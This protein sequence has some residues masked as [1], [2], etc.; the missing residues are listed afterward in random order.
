MVA[1]VFMA[2]WTL[3]ALLKGTDYIVADF[4]ARPHLVAWALLAG[5]LWA[6]ANAL[7]VFAIRDVGLAIAFPLWNLN[8][9]VGM[10]WG[11][12]LFGELRG[13]RRAAARVIGGVVFLMTGAC[14][15]AWATTAGGSGSPVET[16]PWQGVAAALGAGV[17]WG[18]MYIP[19]RKAYISGMNP[20]SFVAIFTVGELVTALALAVAFEGGIDAVIAQLT[21]ARPVL[22][23]LFAGGFCWVIGDLFQQYAAKYVG[24]A[25][26]IPLSN[27]NQL[28]GLAWGMLVFGEL[29]GLGTTT[30]LL[31]IGGSLLMALGALTIGLAAA[32]DAEI[33]SWNAASERECNR[34]GLDR[35]RVLAALKGEDPNKHAGQV[36]RWWE[37]VVAAA[38][39]A[40]AGWLLTGVRSAG[41]E[42]DMFWLAMLSIATLVILVIGSVALWR[43]TRFS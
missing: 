16:R 3:P 19:Y 18:S 29:R 26:G 34:Y 35:A 39:V 24:I 1:G 37:W 33:A 5:M 41:I 6:V 4:S 40:L 43:G 12:L 28:W 21:T 31:V 22:F 25:R 2:R 15:L 30:Q 27:T 23:W 32:P 20:L 38:A 42:M 11:W 10:F 9:L 14:L 17:L 8:S 13:A 36:R 7:T